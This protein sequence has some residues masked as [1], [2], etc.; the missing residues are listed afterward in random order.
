MK[1]WLTYEESVRLKEIVGVLFD[2][3][4]GSVLARLGLRRKL[5]LK[6]KIEDESKQ[7][8]AE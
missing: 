7:S 4:L 6:K 3:H 5:P 1:F 2:N 8:K